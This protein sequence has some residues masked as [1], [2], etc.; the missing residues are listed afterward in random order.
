L[1]ISTYLPE[2]IL[3]KVDRA[4]MYASLEVRAPFLGRAFGEYAMSLPSRDK[5]NGLSTKYLF[6]KLALRHIPREIVE[7]RKH[8]FAPPLSRLLRT[9]LKAPVA[10]ILMDQSSPLNA[11]FYR[12]DIERIWTAHQSGIDQ[13]KKL[14]SLFTLAIA[15]GATGRPAADVRMSRSPL[16]PVQSFAGMSNMVGK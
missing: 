13:R 9:I 15:A 10:D 5:I 16:R 4:A 6:R 7:R 12:H 8:G 11:W 14:W 1:F 3:L 2:D